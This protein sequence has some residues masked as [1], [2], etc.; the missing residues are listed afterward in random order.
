QDLLKWNGWGYKDSKFVVDGTTHH[1]SF[2]GDRYKIG[3]KVLPHFKAWVESA[4]GVDLNV[5]MPA[6]E[7]VK[8]TR[9]SLQG[10]SSVSVNPIRQCVR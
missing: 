10:S 1:I 9:S 2:T 6:K 7:P 8:S 5:L 3:N 4:L